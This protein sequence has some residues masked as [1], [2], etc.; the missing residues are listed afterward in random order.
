MCILH[1]PLG[2]SYLNFKIYN[3]VLHGIHDIN[4]FIFNAFVVLYLLKTGVP[5][6]QTA[7][8]KTVCIFNTTMAFDGI[9][10]GAAM[11]T[12]CFHFVK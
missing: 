12:K 4:N 10:S 3:T 2:R 1:S 7:E 9:T 5:I 8:Q 6:N 11:E